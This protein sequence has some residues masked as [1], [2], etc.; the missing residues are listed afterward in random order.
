MITR[1]DYLNG[2]NTHREYYAQ[3]V[4]KSLKHTVSERFGVETIKLGLAGD[5]NLNT[6]PLNQWDALAGGYRTQLCAAKLREC[7]DGPTL[8]G[9]VCI[10]KEA[11]R[12]VMEDIDKQ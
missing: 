7:G 8:G 5:E 11:A 10:L 4:T 12:Q 2:K 6:I 1:Q 3:F 9:A